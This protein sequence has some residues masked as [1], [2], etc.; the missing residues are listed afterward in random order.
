MSAS[1]RCEISQLVFGKDH[2]IWVGGGHHQSEDEQGPVVE[3]LIK[4]SSTVLELWH[5]FPCV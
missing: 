4:I 5:K 2:K 3:N 1:G